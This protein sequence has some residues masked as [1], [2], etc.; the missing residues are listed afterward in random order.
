MFR[1][2][3][4]Y[5]DREMP[6]KDRDSLDMSLSYQVRELIQ[7]LAGRLPTRPEIEVVTHEQGV[8]FATKVL[9]RSILE[10][11][12]H[13]QFVRFAQALQPRPRPNGSERIP[14]EVVIVPSVSTG[15][16]GGIQPRWGAHCDW[17][18]QTARHQGFTTDIID[19]D[20]L[21]SLTGNAQIIDSF[22]QQ[23]PAQKIILI[24]H[25]RG[26]AE[27]RLLLQKRR[28]VP[29]FRKVRG[30]LNIN[31]AFFGSKLVDLTLSHPVQRRF[32]QLSTRWQGRN[33]AAL[34][35][36]SSSFPA[37][38]ERPY[39]HEQMMVVSVLGL[40][41]R[42]SVSIPLRPNFDRLAA[43]GP[44][45]GIGLAMDAIARPG[46]IYPIS[47]MSYGAEEF[48]F[49][50]VLQRLLLAFE[51][52]ILEPTRLNSAQNQND[53]GE[54]LILEL[55]GAPPARSSAAHSL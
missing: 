42:E 41:G 6:S 53:S 52:T 33:P 30:W 26:A 27:F 50:P 37:W 34:G 17:I 46:M 9:L 54:D 44:N 38:R 45:D 5:Y 36:L 4:H 32:S 11:T 18:R 22:L 31:G 14:V 49:R 39:I 20:P 25:G 29:H 8:E 2:V 3:G 1:L 7:F 55:A 16:V 47:G 15:A 21:G 51:K 13:G 48:V 23:T 35:E 19:T 28:E 43:Y 10:S 12:P 40:P 24:T